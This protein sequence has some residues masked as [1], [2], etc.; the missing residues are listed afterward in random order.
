MLEETRNACILAAKK[1][2]DYQK[3]TVDE[4]ATGYCAAKD[5]GD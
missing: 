5:T 2:G 3:M 4:L 1:L